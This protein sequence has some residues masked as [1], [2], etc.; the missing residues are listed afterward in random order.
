LY[1]CI[2]F[3][4]DG[5]ELVVCQ[6]NGFIKVMD[7]KTSQFKETASEIRVSDNAKKDE[8]ISKAEKKYCI[9]QIEM[10]NDGP[11]FATSDNSKC[12]SL[13]KREYVLT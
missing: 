8:D 4:P 10:S 13:F 2:A 7:M 11:Y 5:S 9:N 3:T 12:V 1:T 6:S